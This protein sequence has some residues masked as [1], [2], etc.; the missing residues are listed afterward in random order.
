MNTQ[1]QNDLV[2]CL[3]TLL[4]DMNNCGRSC[5]VDTASAKEAQAVLR[6]A[7]KEMAEP[8]APPEFRTVSRTEAIHR[9][10]DI[11]RRAILDCP[12][13][14]SFFGLCERHG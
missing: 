13:C 9:L 1:T 14:D 4:N 3:E 12:N 5:N 2:R 6:L 7:K 8:L 11:H 10:A